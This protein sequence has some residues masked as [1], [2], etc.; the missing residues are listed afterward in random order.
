MHLVAGSEDV[1]WFLGSGAAAASCLREAL[2]RN[3]VRLEDLDAVLDF[4]CGA[5]RVTRHWAGLPGPSFHGSDF[6]PALTAWCAR[7]LPFARFQVNR[8]DGGLGYAAETFDLVY[9]LSVFTHLSE[10]LQHFWVDELTRVLRPG[11]HLFLTVHGACYLPRLSASEQERF[12]D[13]QLVVQGVRREGSNDC[14]AFHPEA[15]V[16]RTRA[17]GLE[18]VEFVPEGALGNPRQDAYLLRRP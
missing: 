12:R 17:R 13:D 5:G 1:A 15:Y 8:L 10:P 18:V 2:S 3:G 14:A 6:N 9:A 16:R 7:N 11:G 4:G